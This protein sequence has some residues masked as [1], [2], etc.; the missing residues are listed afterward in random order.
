MQNVGTS[1]WGVQWVWTLFGFNNCNL[2]DSTF[3]KTKIKHT[4]FKNSQLQAVDFTECDLRNSIFDTCELSGAIFA[5]TVI[6]KADF[7]TSFNFTIDPENNKL[8]KAK[9]SKNG[10]SGLLTKYDIII[11][12]AWNQLHIINCQYK[13]QTADL[14]K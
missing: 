1:F 6:E 8:K 3:Y 2:N 9:F 5:N 11:S 12:D 13:I 7:R 4:L 10:L 14:C